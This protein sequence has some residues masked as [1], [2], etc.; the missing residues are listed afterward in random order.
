MSADSSPERARIYT[1]TGDRGE[2]SLYGGRKVSKHD[3]RVEAYGTVDE[4]N[5][6]LGVVVALDPD[7]RLGTGD[8]VAVQSD[9]LTVGATLAA[10][11]PEEARTAGRIPELDAGRI[12]ALETW[13]DRLDASLD[14]LDAFLLPGGS[15]PG[16]QLHL[17]RTVCRRAERTVTRLLEDRP[18][19]STVVVPYLNRLSDLLFTLARSVNHRSGTNEARWEPM[20]RR[21]E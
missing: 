20:R 11:D 15:P 16:A 8:L 12:A 14:P 9:L 17:A 2:T 18:D 10:A 13:I 21:S 4:L 5:A 6:A 19:L 7:D 3:A 1:R